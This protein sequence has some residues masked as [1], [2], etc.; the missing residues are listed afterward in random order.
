MPTESQL[1]PT[2]KEIKAALSLCND[3]ASFEQKCRTELKNKN[4]TLSLVTKDPGTDKTL[5]SHT[6]SLDQVLEELEGKSTD[7]FTYFKTHKE[8]ETYPGE[9]TVTVKSGPNKTYIGA[10]PRVIF[11]GSGTKSDTKAKPGTAPT[12]TPSSSL[13]KDILTA[14]PSVVSAIQLLQPKQQTGNDSKLILDFMK[15]QAENMDRLQDQR[16]EDRK[17]M[18]DLVEN[19]TNSRSPIAELAELEDF[20][21]TVSANTRPQTPPLIGGASPTASAWDRL[22][23][24]GGKYLESAM[25]AHQQRAQTVQQEETIDA[26]RAEISERAAAEPVNV[27][28]YLEDLARLIQAE[29][30]PISVLK[31]VQETLTFAKQNNQ[32]EQIPALA[33]NDN[34]LE[35]A[36]L[37]LLE[38]STDNQDYISQTM[39]AAEP[40]IALV[41]AE[42]GLIKTEEVKAE[43]NGK[44]DFEHAGTVGI[45]A[46]LEESQP[47]KAG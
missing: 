18:K 38:G 23:D 12:P 27:S 22:A 25:Q 44:S 39:K 6:F 32:L 15:F 13:T 9:Y 24:L 7:L 10:A 40:F 46:S 37:S 14:L 36:L 47:E 30:E 21:Q 26:R 33:E 5:N 41:A 28:V 35:L 8:I 3:F 2:D 20:R 42:L 34:D 43:D 16:K 4:I 17:E 31:G 19:I 1:S 45:A 29:T 11:K